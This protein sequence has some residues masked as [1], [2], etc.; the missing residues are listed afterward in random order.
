MKTA[1]A[2]DAERLC[3][4][5]VGEL[6]DLVIRRAAHED[7][8]DIAEIYNYYVLGSTVT[9]DTE[10]KSAEDRIRWMEEHDELYPVLVGEIDGE[11]V[12][13]GALTRWALRPAWRHTVEISVYVAGD[14]TGRGI[15]PAM[16]EAL[17]SEATRLGHHAVIAQIVA[18]N[19]VSLVMSQRQGFERV[20]ILREV[21]RK[22]DRWLDVVLVERILGDPYGWEN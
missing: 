10:P 16:T 5:E 11:I 7:A 3:G 6:V 1:S 20:G 17:V 2:G 8:E 13:W 19:G 14:S 18:E 12:A 22:F 4:L 21:G 9:F 15:G